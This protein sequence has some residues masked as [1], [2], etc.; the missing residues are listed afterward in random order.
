MTDNSREEPTKTD[1]SLVEKRMKPKDTGS[2]WSGND[3]LPARRDDLVP[4]ESVVAPLTTVLMPDTQ[5]ARGIVMQWKKNQLDRKTTLQ[6]L[7]SYYDAQLEKLRYRLR[8]DVGVSNAAADRTAEEFLEKLDTE[9]IQILKDLGL[10][11]TE[12][13]AVL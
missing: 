3:A 12:T 9:H 10:R 2:T 11:N 1:W 13:R 5:A 7:E 8:K 6:A 4:A